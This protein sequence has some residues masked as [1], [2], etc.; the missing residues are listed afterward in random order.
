MATTV[1][2]L[3]LQQPENPV[4]NPEMISYTDKTW[5]RD[6]PPINNFL[7]HTT[8]DEQ[9][10]VQANFDSAFLPLDADDE[11][12]LSETAYPP[13]ARRWRL[14]TE[15]D[16]EHWWHTE[17]SDVVLAAWSRFPSIVQTSH[18]KPLSD[19]NIPENVDSTYAMYIANMRAAVVIG[20]TKRNLINA[21][22]WQRGHLTRP[23]M[24][25]ASELRGLVGR[26]PSFL[27]SFSVSPFLHIS[28]NDYLLCKSQP[29]S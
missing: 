11:T 10:L 29:P 7:I 20:E 28:P 5:A 12:R 14:E 23:Q 9:G 25:L 24:K 22:E 13:N 3:I 6:Y 18:T 27:C 26:L 15:A 8:M 2:S 17:V 4:D 21:Q 16:M 19:V 1:R